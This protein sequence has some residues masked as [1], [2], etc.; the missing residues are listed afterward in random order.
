M[1]QLETLLGIIEKNEAE[2]MRLMVDAVLSENNQHLVFLTGT[3]TILR[4]IKDTLVSMQGETDFEEAI[5]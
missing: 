4:D 3:L 1:Q 5:H 2:T